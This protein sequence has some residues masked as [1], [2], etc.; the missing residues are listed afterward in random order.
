MIIKYTNKNYEEE[1]V[2][3]DKEY[4]VFG[5]GYNPKGL[6]FII[7]NDQQ[8][9]IMAKSSDCIVIDDTPSKYWKIFNLSLEDV[10]IVDP[11]WTYDIVEVLY[12][13]IGNP[14]LIYSSKTKQRAFIDSIDNIYGESGVTDYIY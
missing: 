2:A 9:I 6:W 12:S 3:L 13:F 7:V 10:Y 1:Y 8:Q 14:Q 5:I 4:I 11:S